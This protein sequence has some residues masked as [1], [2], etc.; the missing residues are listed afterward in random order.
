MPMDID[1]EGEREASHAEKE[2]VRETVGTRQNGE[3]E[4]KRG[5]QK[6]KRERG[7]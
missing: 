2:G 4:R 7:G 5:I 6:R 3:M 1:I